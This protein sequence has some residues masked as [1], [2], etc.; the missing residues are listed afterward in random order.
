MGNLAKNGSTMTVKRVEPAKPGTLKRMGG[1]L[2]HTLADDSREQDD[3]DIVQVIADT[4]IGPTPGRKAARSAAAVG[5]GVVVGGVVGGSIT[6]MV[7]GGVTFLVGG[8][9]ETIQFVK[10]RPSKVVEAEVTNAPVIEANASDEQ[11]VDAVGLA[12]A[13][14]AENNLHTALKSTALGDIFQMSER[15]FE[16]LWSRAQANAN[17][18]KKDQGIY[19]SIVRLAERE[20]LVTV[21]S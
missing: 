10:G 1:W 14:K 12:N 11:V 3:R 18:N 20:G 8:V 9:A 4:I 7:I 19:N 16:Q 6:T 17:M 5:A 2:Y 15:K 21:A 13:A